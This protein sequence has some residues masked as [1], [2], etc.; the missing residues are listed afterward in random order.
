MI[1]W[2]PCVIVFGAR[3]KVLGRDEQSPQRLGR[4]HGEY[5]GE[6]ELVSSLQGGG[7]INL[8]GSSKRAQIVETHLLLLHVVEEELDVGC[9]PIDWHV[10]THLHIR[11]VVRSF[12]F[13]NAV[14]GGR[15][16]VLW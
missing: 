7:K 3:T 16:G 10:A 4:A 12:L 5:V 15:E 8:W 6:A 2:V 13:E 9:R 11:V 14:C 1:E